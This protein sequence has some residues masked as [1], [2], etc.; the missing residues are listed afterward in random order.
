MIRFGYNIIIGIYFGDIAGQSS[1]DRAWQ[2][3]ERHEASVE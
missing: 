1:E 2:S 3:T